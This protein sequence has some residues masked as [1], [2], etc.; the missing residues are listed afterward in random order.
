MKRLVKFLAANV[1]IVAMLVAMLPVKYVEAAETSEQLVSID[2]AQGAGN[3]ALTGAE[4]VG[5]EVVICI[6]TIVVPTNSVQL[7]S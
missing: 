2:F 1:F 7:A 5:M 6:E 3:V 4:I